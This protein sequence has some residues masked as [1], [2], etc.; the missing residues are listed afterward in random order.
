MAEGKF[1]A[2]LFY[3]LNVYPIALPPL[4]ERQEDLG[5]LTMFFLK[6][7]SQELKKEVLGISKEAMGLLERYTWPGNVRELEEVI[8]QAVIRCQGPRSRH[9]SLP[10]LREHLR[11]C[12]RAAKPSASRP[13]ASSWPSWRRS[14]SARPWSRPIRIS[15]TLPRS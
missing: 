7:Y 5:P 4:R 6:R 9:R 13:V 1:R 2:D 11:A 14:S 12:P 8:E 10:V 3:R 15:H